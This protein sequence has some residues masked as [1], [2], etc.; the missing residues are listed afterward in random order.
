MARKLT[1]NR[2]ANCIAITRSD[3]KDGEVSIEE[4][5]IEKQKLQNAKQ[6]SV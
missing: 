6:L 3:D 2:T 1:P 5:I 4:P